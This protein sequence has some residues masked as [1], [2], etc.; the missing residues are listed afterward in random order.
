MKQSIKQFALIVISL[1]V[2]SGLFAQVT[3]SSMSGRITEP[4]GAAIA[5]ATVVAVHVPSGSKYY[6][7]ADNAGNYRIQNMRVGGPY[8]VEVV[9]LG[10]GTVKR[11]GISLRLGET[12]VY[13]AQLKEEALSLSE[14][15]ISAGLVNPILNSNR[16]GASMNISSREMTSLPSI[17]RSLTDFTRMT[18][19]ANGNSFAGRDGRFNTVTI[20]GAAFNNNFGLSS[21]AMPGGSSQPISLD[22]IEQVSVNLAPYDVR[23]SQFTGAS[24]NAVTKS[25]DNKLKVTAYTYL[26]P[27]TFT[28]EKVGESIVNNA[29]LRSSSTYGITVGGPIIK[30]KLFLFASY[31]YEKETSPSNA[32]EP[33]TNGVA[34]LTNR[35]S[36]TTVAD[37]ERAKNHLLSAYNY[38]PGEYQNFSSFPSENY[39]ILARLDWNIARNHKFAFRYNRLRN[40]STSLTNATSGPPSVPRNNNSR[41]GEYSISF[42]NAFYGNENA[43]DAFAGELNSTFG[44]RFSNK[45]LVSYTKTMDP[46]RTS[47]SDIFPFVDIYKDG[48]PYMSFG[49]ELFTYRNQVLN[50]TFSVVNNLS[51]NLNKHTITAG[52]A[53]DNIFVNNSYIREGTSYYRYA[54]L[55]DFINNAKPTGFGVTYGY[56][57]ADPKGVEM[58]F[59]LG[60]LYLQDEWIMNKQFKLTYGI[61]AEYP[62]YHNS[63]MDN[64]AISALKFKDGFKFD[65]STWPNTKLQINPRVGFNWD[66]KGDR[67]LQVRGGTGLFTGVLPF[68][69]FTNQPTSSGTVQS[70][71]IGITGA[72]LPA[73]FRF[74][75]DFRAQV[76]KYPGLFPQAVSTTL[77][78]GAALAQVAKDFKMPRIWRSNLAADIELPGNMILTLEALFSKDVNAVVQKNM[79][80]PGQNKVFFGPDNRPYWSGNRVN[81]GVSSAMLLTN[82][83]QGYQSLLTAQ[84][85]KNFSNGLSGMVAYTYN[86]S[87]DVSSNPGSSAASAWTSNLDVFDLNNPQL[88]HS[89]FAVPHRVVGTISYRVEYIKHLATTFSLYYNGAA[90][91]RSSY[92]YS[93]DMNGDNAASDL[94][95][96]PNNANELTFVDVAGKM[97]AAEQAAKF[98]QYVE[99]DSYLS[100]RKGQYAERFARV[101]PWRNRWDAKI[102]QDVFTNFGSNRR[103]TLQFSLDIVNAGNLLN[104]DWGHFTRSGLA[105]QYDVIMP[106]TYKGVN[107][108]GVPTFTLNATD[109]AH[110]DT[111]NQQ[112]KSVTT[113]STWGMLFGVRFIF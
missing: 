3:T 53:Y 102:L 101:N 58:S 59:G 76:A 42:S 8:E 4:D 109:I 28:G 35:I 37:L 14:V 23:L 2:T 107:S 67:S 20:D 68:V 6:S 86:V 60:S 112:V 64:P 10:F 91:G 97:T 99:G 113:G 22:A 43:I 31:E 15:V 66:V 21:S 98:W 75:P 69:W 52:I 87:K 78:S 81:S 80:L 47:N 57:G 26:R 17:S 96:V 29:R 85:T 1:L 108:E 5:G 82:S 38:D 83:S 62:M 90:M 100:T 74:N 79:N 11:G 110:F 95:Y 49:Y 19:Q 32:W 33:S 71:E 70:P 7:V 89:N 16:T 36:R 9:F 34:D 55:D 92:A 105:N 24:I 41:V 73:D 30:D 50:N 40:T 65:V 56:N 103:Y 63:L 12:F 88:S 93:N 54:S 51:I 39:K 61:R 45:F 18:P 106:L 48:N 27:K 13:D 25:G 77:A 72:N 46:R 104:K 111:K 84:L 44:N 94:I